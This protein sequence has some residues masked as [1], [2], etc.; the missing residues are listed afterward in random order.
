MT[1]SSSKF[2][3]SQLIAASAISAVFCAMMLG[4]AEG[5]FTLSEQKE[6]APEMGEIT[7]YVLHSSAGTFQFVPPR[8]WRSIVDSAGRRLLLQSSDQK[9]TFEL[10]IRGP[11]AGL[12]PGADREA[13]R[14]QVLTEFRG[15][16]I[17]AEFPFYTASHNGRA[18]DVQ[19]LEAGQVEMTARVAYFST[20]RGSIE[21][22]LR[23]MQSQVR[24]FQPVFGGVVTSLRELSKK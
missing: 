16:K 20:D 5:D 23:T 10:T 7:L 2:H 12:R 21:C 3:C 14:S 19:W 24:N 18:F 17:A 22:C 13:L 6:M 8:G 9:G 4:A 11:I 15:A 1:L